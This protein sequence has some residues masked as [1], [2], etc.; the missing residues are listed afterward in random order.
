MGGAFSSPVGGVSSAL[1]ERLLRQNAELTGFVSRLTEEKN[2]LRNQ[3]LKL[4]EDLRKLRHLQSHGVST[5]SSMQNNA[6]CV[7]VNKLCVC[8]FLQSV[9]RPEAPGFSSSSSSSDWEMWRKEKNGLENSLHQAQVEITRLRSE[10][11]SETLRDTEGGVLKV[12]HIKSVHLHFNKS[13]FILCFCIWNRL[14]VSLLIS[15]KL[16]ISFMFIICFSFLFCVTY[17]CS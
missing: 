6:V 2:E 4:E 16:K 11:R 1:S 14:F 9:L 12:R 15:Y 3:I 10:I 17:F 5:A 8:V 7:A 13:S